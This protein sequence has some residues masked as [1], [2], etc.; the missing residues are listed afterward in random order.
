MTTLVQ[1]SDHARPILRGEGFFIHPG[2]WAPGIRSFRA[3][4]FSAKATIISLAF[5]V[6]MLVLQ[7]WLLK[8]DADHAM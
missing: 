2:L 1:S 7:D 6:P 3:L 5:M 8:T 4:R